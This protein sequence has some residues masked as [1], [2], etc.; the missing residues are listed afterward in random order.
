MKK[1]IR[2]II[3]IMVLGLTPFLALQVFAA[4]EG[5]S[6]GG[7]GITASEGLERGDA[8]PQ[9]MTHSMGMREHWR[10]VPPTLM[11]K[12]YLWERY[13]MGHRHFL[14]LTIQQVDEIGSSLNAQRRYWIGKRA[15]RTILIMEIHELLLKDPVDLKK[16]E[17]KVKAVQAL[18]T[19]MAM[20]EIRT[21]EKVL[22][23]LNHEQ[24]K[25]VE[26]FMRESTFTRRI[27]AY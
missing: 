6:M 16:V 14:G 12:I 26:D 20:E 23:I 17:E 11:G 18:S 24:R 4:Q 22:S 2:R 7:Q 15:N 8:E 1:N 10:S 5:T 25:A 21:L 19:E 27:R 9:Q 13:V 3:W